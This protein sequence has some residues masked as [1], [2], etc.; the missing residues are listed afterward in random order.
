MIASNSKFDKEP[1][2]TRRKGI[3]KGA[4]CLGCLNTHNCLSGL[5]VCIM[6]RRATGTG[7][8]F[9]GFEGGGGKGKGKGKPGTI[10]LSV[11][12]AQVCNAENHCSG[13]FFPAIF[14]TTY[15]V[16]IK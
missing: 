2:H 5:S 12:N 1:V 14:L 7:L 15:D 8:W 3:Q 16:S 4:E 11:Y 13:A 6:S 9:V 10:G